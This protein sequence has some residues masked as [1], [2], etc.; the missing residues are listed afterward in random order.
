MLQTQK[1]NKSAKPA[2]STASLPD[3]IFMLLFFFMMV[4]VLRNSDLML[5]INTP[6]ASQLTLLEEASLV[7]HIY[8]GQP[9]QQFQRIYGTAPSIQLADRISSVADI[10]H[11]LEDHRQ[12]VP[13]AMRS[14]IISSLE[15]DGEVT[16]GIL[17]DVKTELRK[18][19]QLK[20]SYASSLV[21]K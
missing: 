1:P 17:Q 11:F 12:T 8:I 20:V 14:R 19:N 9:K 6:D 3:I 18:S 15:V 7:N 21:V 10:A 5:D 2:I 13:E 4:T 16:M